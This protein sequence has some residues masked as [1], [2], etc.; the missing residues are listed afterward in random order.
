V[1]TV[2]EVILD[3]VERRTA[4]LLAGLEVPDGRVYEFTSQTGTSEPL[5]G[6]PELPS[7]RALL[8]HLLGEG[9]SVR[10]RPMIVAK[11][12]AICELLLGQSTEGKGTSRQLLAAGVPGPRG[13]QGF[14]HCSSPTHAAPPPADACNE[15]VGA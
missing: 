10:E 1:T 5:G 13:G 15:L 3:G 8:G 6:P 12:A 9:R 14:S 2:T 11:G 4:Y 7:R